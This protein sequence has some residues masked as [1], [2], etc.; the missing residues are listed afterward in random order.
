MKSAGGVFGR[1]GNTASLYR[2]LEAWSGQPFEDYLRIRATDEA[3][4]GW[5]QFVHQLYELY[6]R[7]CDDSG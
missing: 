7:Y 2:V 3:V 4:S 6:S 5:G 1:R